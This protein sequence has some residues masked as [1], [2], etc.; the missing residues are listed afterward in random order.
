[1]LIRFEMDLV[2]Y[3]RVSS[4]FI[5]QFHCICLTDTISFGSLN[6]NLELM[7]PIRHLSEREAVR[8]MTLLEEGYSQRQ[9]AR[10]IGCHHTTIGRTLQRF[11]ETGSNTRRPGQGRP[12][13]T[14]E[15]DDRFLRLHALRTRQVTSSEMSSLLQSTRNV[16]ISAPTVR[17]R[18]NEF[19]L[20]SRRVA[21]GPLLTRDHRVARLRFARDHLNWSFDAWKRVLFSDEVRIAL[22]SPDGRART[23]R[24][25]GERFAQCNII[26]R[27]AFGGGSIMFWGGISMEARTELVVVP[28]RS[29]NAPRYVEEILQPHVVPFARNIGQGFLFMQDNARPHRARS[30]EEFLNEQ[31]IER[32]EWPARSP[33]LNP[34]EHIWDQLKKRIRSRIQPPSNLSQL[35]Q[36]ALEEW[37]NIPQERVKNLINSMRRRLDAVIKARGGNTRY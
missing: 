21:S 11:N 20:S 22:N 7:A 23:W 6:F 15:R 27:V 12:R 16:S 24:R 4:W 26:P 25:S 19:G 37:E 10:I 29:L 31:N 33:D 13:A 28:G 1:M 18:L 3:T 17:R 35:R 36:A 34:I 2:R 5:P 30:V 14:T 9:V 8:A 32:I